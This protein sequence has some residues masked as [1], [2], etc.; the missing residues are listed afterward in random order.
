LLEIQQY[1]AR[2]D[3]YSYFE[4]TVT[5]KMILPFGVVLAISCFWTASRTTSAV[6]AFRGIGANES[7]L[8][9][10]NAYNPIPSPNGKYIGY[11]ETGWGREGGSGGT[12][13]SN[14]ISDV[15]VM[16]ANDG[17]PSR[18]ILKDFFLSGWTPEGD[19]LVCFRDWQFAVVGIDGKL[20]I[21]GR[22][23]YDT[24]QFQAASEWVAFSPAFKTVIWSRWIGGTQRSI[25]TPNRQI[26][27]DS[28][29]LWPERPIPSPDGR[30]IAVFSEDT[31]R[32]PELRVF[33]VQRRV[34]SSLGE[35]T[36]HPDRQWLYIQPNWNPWFA[37]SSRLVLIQDHRLVVAYPDGRKVAE[38][39]IE[40]VSGLPTASPDGKRIAYVT[41]E[42]RPMSVRPDLHFWGGTTVMVVSLESRLAPQ[43]VTEKNP[44]EVYDLK[45]LDDSTVLFDRV[46]DEGLFQHARI[47]KA[48]LLK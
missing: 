28:I 30:Y 8:R 33:D 27:Q 23:P 24:N 5:L 14:L 22:I 46:A 41:F 39:N 38:F 35:T 42:P 21:A 4:E 36:I 25:E 16:S 2:A 29:A 48:S 37:D 12:G 18:T 3:R 20:E 47:W 9:A 17:T 1:R 34:W 6:E 32:D 44:D 43:A 13:R 26:A 19:R 10:D 7:L 15:K 45:W 40:G 11:V 31:F